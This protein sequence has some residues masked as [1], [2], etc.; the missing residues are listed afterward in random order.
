M[1]LPHGNREIPLMLTDRN[2][3]TDATGAL[4]GQ[5]LFKIPVAP[6]GAP[7]PFTG[8]FNLVNGTIWPYLD[9]EPRWYRFR[10]LNACNSRFYRLNL[11][12]DAGVAHND[13][14]RIIGT[15]GGL[16]PA[17][18]ELPAAGLTLA[19]AERADL[20]VDF[21][22]FPGQSLKL[23]DTSV[24][25]PT[26]PDLMQFRVEDGHRHDSFVLPEKLS[27]TYVRLVHGTTVPEDHDHVFVG[28]VPPGTAGE[29]HPQ[30]WELQ[31]LDEPPATLP[32]AGIIQL[33]D[34]SSGAVRTFQKVAQLFDD[35]TTF[36][37]DHGR[38]AVWNLVHLGGSR[39]T[40]RATSRVS[41]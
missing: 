28:L 40:R 41:T 8:P 30:M 26:E 9:V 36:F 38:W 31:E 17:P 7:I 5:L 29:A 33:T 4:T 27:S 3:D 10:V 1:Y 37:I 34:P 25:G 15:D 13:A 14:V 35:T 18:A 16:L 2:L 24:T 39:R 6:S 22:K 23:T 19:P 21:S 11:V 12:D 20:L 32:A